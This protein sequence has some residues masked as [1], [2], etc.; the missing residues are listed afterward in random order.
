MQCFHFCEQR[1]LRIYV[2][3]VTIAS[4][5]HLILSI[6]DYRHIKFQQFPQFSI[7]VHI[8]NREK[9]E[10]KLFEMVVTF[11][12]VFDYSK[13]CQLTLMLSCWCSIDLMIFLFYQ[14][15]LTKLNILIHILQ[16]CYSVSIILFLHKTFFKLGPV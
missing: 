5:Q 14:Y 4:V 7:I 13:R 3:K 16:G 1:F 11:L 15:I 2:D 9:F 10:V 6:T 12:C 8:S